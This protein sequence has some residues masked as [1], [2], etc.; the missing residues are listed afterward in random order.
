MHTSKLVSGFTFLVKN[1]LKCRGKSGTLTRLSMTIKT[2]IL[3][4]IKM[5]TSSIYP[6]GI[7]KA[8]QLTSIFS[9][10]NVIRDKSALLRLRVSFTGG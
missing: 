9:G 3:N 2:L 10:Y 6:E 5:L 7:S 8:K 1:L 4:T